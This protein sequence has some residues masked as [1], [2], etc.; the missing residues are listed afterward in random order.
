[1]TDS[2]VT[3]VVVPR[4]RFSCA[5]ESLESIYRETDV[6]FEL[7]YVDGG[8]PP[9]IRRYLDAQARSRGFQ[10]VRTDCYLSPNEARNLGLR[11]VDT[12]YVVFIDNDVVVTPGWLGKMVECADETSAGVVGP[13]TC[14]GR[15][16]HEII[17]LAG[18][19]VE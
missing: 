9:R 11:D 1:M 8:S 5:P 14:I 13:L 3:V 10:L 2:R 17:H 15:P 4:E 7:V 16:E 18:G 19:R 6:P 12:E